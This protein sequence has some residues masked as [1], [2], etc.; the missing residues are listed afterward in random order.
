MGLYLVET[1]VDLYGGEIKIEDNQPSGTVF[2]V[3]LDIADRKEKL[4]T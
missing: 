2:T 4:P 1:L 3:K